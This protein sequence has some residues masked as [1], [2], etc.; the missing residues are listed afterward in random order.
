M[1]ARFLTIYL[2]VCGSADHL[3]YREPILLNFVTF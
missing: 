2:R 1:D 3:G